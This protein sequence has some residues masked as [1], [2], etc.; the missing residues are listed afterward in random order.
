M[1]HRLATALRIRPAICAG[2]LLAPCLALAALAPL[3]ARAAEF[4][5]GNTA[6]FAQN[7]IESD[8]ALHGGSAI[9]QPPAVTGG[10]YAD[11]FPRDAGGAGRDPVS[12]LPGRG[13]VA[14][15]SADTAAPAAAALAPPAEPITTSPRPS[16]RWQSLVP[17]VL[18]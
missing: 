16:Y 7:I 17:G 14:D 13:Q 15:T 6:T 1:N 8:S 3:F 10:G 2:L 12:A 5:V 18:K 4:P 9:P 11:A